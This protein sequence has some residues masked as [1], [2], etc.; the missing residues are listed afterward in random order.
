[1]PSEDAL[2]KGVTMRYSNKLIYRIRYIF[3]NDTNA[4]RL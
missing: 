3:Y 4:E 1:M 2:L